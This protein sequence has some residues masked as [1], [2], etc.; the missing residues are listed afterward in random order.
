MSYKSL[1]FL[2][3]F[4]CGQ[5][6]GA[7]ERE[8]SIPNELNLDW[9]GELVYFESDSTPDHKA[10][11][12]EIDGVV[13]PVQIEEVAGKTRYWSYVRVPKHRGGEPAF[14]ARLSHDEVRPGIRLLEEGDFYLI[15][16]GTYQFRLRNFDG[17]LDAPV[18]LH[19]FPHWIGGMRTHNQTGWDGRAWYDGNG[20]VTAARTEIIQQGPVFVD[21]KVTLEFADSETG[22]QVEALPLALGKQSYLWEPNAFPRE[23]IKKLKNH[24]EVLI[25]FVMDDTWIDVNE[26]FHF[27]RDPSSKPWGISQ[28]WL[29]WGDPE[30]APEL[31]GF[32]PGEH[33]LV[34]VVTW[35]RWFLYDKFGGNSS[36]GVVPAE[37][38]DDQK[39]RPFA[40]LR[41]RW[42]QGGGGAQDFVVTGGGRPEPSVRWLRRSYLKK[43]IRKVLKADSHPHQEEVKAL[44]EI[45]KNR[46]LSDDERRQAAVKIG[47]LVGKEVRQLQEN[48]SESN[49]AAG[50]VAAYASK[51][52]GPYPATIAAYAYDENRA[53]IRFPMIDG[54]RSGKHYGQRAYGLLVGARGD[55]RSLNNIVRRHTDWTLVAEINKY[56]LDWD[57][58]GEVQSAGSLPTG[59]LFIKRRYQDDYLNPT[60]RAT[61]ELVQLGQARRKVGADAPIGGK[62]QATLG[63]IFTDP[64]HWPG[65]HHGWSP[66]NPNFH[67][68]KYMG[69]V[70]TA[71]ALPEHPHAREWLE[72]GLQNFK[73][74]ISKAV[75]G[76]DGV[77]VECPGYSGYSLAHQLDIMRTLRDNGLE[78][79]VERAAE[80]KKNGLWHRKLIT[81]YD[82]RIGHRHEAPHGDTHRWSSGLAAGFGK[83]AYL[84]QDHDPLFAAE[85]LGT[86]QLLKDSGDRSKKLNIDKWLG[87][88]TIP[89]SPADPETMDWSSQA[90][91]G[92]GAVLRD[93]FGTDGESFVSIKAGFTSGHYH[94]DDMAFHFYS[95]GDPISLDYNCSYSPRGD[96]AGLHNKL[97]FGKTGNLQH[98]REKYAFEGM[99]QAGGRAEVL[100]FESTDS[101][102][103]LVAELSSD[104][105]TMSPVFPKDH[106]FNRKYPSRDVDPIT[107]RRSLLFIK[108]A[109][110]SEGA[111]YL[112]VRDETISSEPQQIN[113]HLLA[114]NLKVQGN[115]VAATGQWGKDMEV[116]FF[117]VDV[118][119][120]LRIEE[121]AWWYY[122]RWMKGPGERYEMNEGE[123]HEAYS[124]RMSKL[125]AL[126]AADW[127]PEYRKEKADESYKPWRDLIEATQGRALIP[128]SGWS[129]EMPWRF[130]EYQKWLHVHTG[131]SRDVVWV[132]YPHEPGEKPEI[133]YNSSR[134]EL[135]V[136]HKGG[137]DRIDFSDGID[138]HIDGNSEQ[139]LKGPDAL[140]NLGL[141][142]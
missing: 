54:E 86:L 42:N 1:L 21:F 74:D 72:Y 68:D 84:Y 111:D 26:R 137:S 99:E 120:D 41:P 78:S 135:T 83:L 133:V 55:F 102:D 129:K 18:P 95:G 17:A 79:V 118:E 58:G 90:F 25:R 57:R 56:V 140:S 127:A 76:P 141:D 130:G 20:M 105:L 126:P 93:G 40:L 3:L 94:N 73:D 10:T 134:R 89:V 36:Q 122:D 116:A 19:E 48:Y 107:H 2:L 69:A 110:G 70:Y 75:V 132:L 5:I 53:Q 28:Y 67:T 44:N 117:P 119:G 50:I 91:E 23:K 60:Q 51:W 77:G 121:R 80:V 9:P 52:V 32:A 7:A 14:V 39:G 125:N 97:T 123:T 66:G 16:N 128:P 46:K 47:E 81:P 11:G 13:T 64:D 37:P 63:Y 29:Q 31:P 131:G 101:A 6:T 4:V 8:W 138:V 30:G 96:H 85:M 124:A 100:A 104:R 24:Y 139:F 34:D 88:S 87:S 12:I 106:E 61:R 114:S 33:M 113:L 142:Q 92:F 15:D 43:E 109:D 103:L 82:Y 38:R 108:H 49:P 22:E 98:N 62:W 71:S 27:P 115:R 45:L 112:V 65:W 136:R 59:E 35:V